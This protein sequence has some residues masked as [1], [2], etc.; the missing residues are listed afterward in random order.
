MHNKSMTTIRGNYWDFRVGINEEEMFKRI[1]GMISKARKQ[2]ENEGGV[3]IAHKEQFKK[4]LF[5]FKG[6]VDGWQ[7]TCDTETLA[8]CNNPQTLNAWKAF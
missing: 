3:C 7:V 6:E 5:R 4:G 8:G 2:V 1:K